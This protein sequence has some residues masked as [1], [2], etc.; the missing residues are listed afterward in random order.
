MSEPSS[1]ASRAGPTPPSP[2][3]AADPPGRLDLEQVREILPA[4]I[5]SLGDA[6]VIVDRQRRVVAANR[7]YVEAFGT[8]RAD[9]VGS[10]CQEAVHC[11]ELRQAEGAERCVACEV[12]EKRQ[13]TRH[14][15]SLPDAGGGQRR[16]EATL[17]PIL[18]RH[19]EVT[20]VVELWRDV[21]ER[22]QLEVQL[23]HSERLASVGMLAAGV[24]HE[25][26]NPLASLMA[27]VDVLGRWL[28]RR[29]FDEE[30]LREARE[31]IAVLEHEIERC[32]QTTEK[33]I[34]LGRA[35][36]T[37]PSWVDLNLA[38]RDTLALLRYELRRRGIEEVERLDPD[39]PRIW[40]REAGM[41]GVCM[42]LMLNAVQAMS[43]GGR[44][45]ITTRR[46]GDRALLVVEDTGPGIAPEHLGRIW[47]PFFTT[48]PVG[49]GTGLGL[50]ITNRIVARHRGSIG[51]ES[52][53]GRGTTFT[54]DL[55]I[56]GPGGDE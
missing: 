37:T 32:R 55:P 20:H 38:V 24:G 18:D 36:A 54:V 33:L 50:S 21:T 30:A 51:V 34:L 52:A 2:S 11:P 42:N 31:T 56:H 8:M 17:N 29:R 4:L 6:V 23:S 26:N 16:W 5:D 43:A 22:S 25:I 53:P 9:I 14:L 39:L 44:L 19:G 27:A 41:R 10:A 48:K 13:P 46:R 12:I 15:R 28:Q 49:Q 45:S 40:A 1:P 3:Q 47:D 35:Y 7:R